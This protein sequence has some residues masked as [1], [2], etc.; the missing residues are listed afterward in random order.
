MQLTFFP[1]YN[2]TFIKCYCYIKSHND[3]LQLTYS[4]VLYHRRVFLFQQ[5]IKVV[6]IIV[7]DF[8]IKQF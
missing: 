6:D 4:Q 2:T 3:L 5:T 1:L 7:C 8:R